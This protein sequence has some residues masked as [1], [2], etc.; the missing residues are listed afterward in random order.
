[1]LS[2]ISPRVKL[3]VIV[4]ICLAIAGYGALIF[5]TQTGFRIVRLTPEDTLPTSTRVIAM[6]FNKT[7]KDLEQQ[8][9]GFVNLEPGTDVSLSIRDK[10]LVLTL[11]QQLQQGTELKVMLTD[12][13]AEDGSTLSEELKYSVKFV[14]YND[15]SE[16]EQRRQADNSIAPLDRHPL[17]SI[18]PYDAISYRIEYTITDDKKFGTAKDWKAEKDNFK[19]FIYTFALKDGTDEAYRQKHMVLRED[20][21][22][23]IKD[24]GVDP[25]NDITIVYRPSNEELNGAPA[26]TEEEFDGDGEAPSDSNPN[27]TDPYLL[28]TPQ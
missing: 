1:M 26:P 25:D 7:L 20:A 11:N 10:S 15:L 23:W 16:E 18:L 6:E 4:L 17:L 2:R 9:P 21:K 22:A 8:N 12:I 13:M 19:V 5:S 3:I 24:L 27:T 28:D 14:P